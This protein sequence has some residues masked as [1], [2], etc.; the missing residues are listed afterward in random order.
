MAYFDKYGVEFSDDRKTLVKCPIVFKGE[1][2]IPN[3][4]TSIENSAFYGCEGLTSVTIPNSVTSIGWAAFGNCSSLTS[5]IL[6]SSLI[7]ID[8]NAFYECDNLKEIIVPKG[9]K[10]RFSQMDGLRELTDKIIEER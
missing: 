10:E 9:Q 6:P 8:E 2:I 1:Y 7:K 3:S 5:I 4:A